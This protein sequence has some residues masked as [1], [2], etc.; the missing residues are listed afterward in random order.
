MMLASLSN[1]AELFMPLGFIWLCLLAVTG[2]KFYRKERREGTVVLGIV[3]LMWLIGSTPLSNALLGSLERPYAGMEIKPMPKVDA[4]ILLGGGSWPS[5]YEAGQMHLNRA[6]DRTMMAL[7]LMK[8]G[9]ADTLIIGGGAKRGDGRMWRMSENAKSW[10][11]Q[12]HFLDPATEI[13]ALPRCSATKNE[14][15]AT[16]KVAIERGWKTFYLVTSANHMRRAAGVFRTTGLNVNEAPCAF[17]TPVS[18]I[19]ADDWFIIPRVG[20]FETMADYCH[21]I[22][23]WYY[24]RLRGWI[25][26][27]AAAQKTPWF[28]K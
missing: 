25:N 21:E 18:L 5:R 6:G 3:F 12:S 7:F 23:G 17:Q 16:R 26:A 27:E 14:A 28:K 9:K 13:I 2:W 10:I 1:I 19:G 24:Y 15:E 20:R 22:I 4:V 11:E 8:Q